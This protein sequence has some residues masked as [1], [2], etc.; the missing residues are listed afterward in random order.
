MASDGT[1]ETP[2]SR[3][4]KGPP[5][6]SNGSVWVG[7]CR[8]RPCRVEESRR[9]CASNQGRAD[10]FGGSST[11]RHSPQPHSKY[12]AIRIGAL[13][14]IGAIRTSIMPALHVGQDGRETGGD[15][16]SLTTQPYGVGEAFSGTVL[17]PAEI[18][19]GPSMRLHG[20]SA[21]CCRR[22]NN[23]YARK[24]SLNGYRPTKI[25]LGSVSAPGR[26]DQ[27]GGPRSSLT[28]SRTLAVREAMVYGFCSQP[29]GAA[30]AARRCAS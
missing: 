8:T 19:G 23:L 10:A 6:D 30:G 9:G 27:S 5:Q 14:S 25:G 7:G 28:A 18:R 2:N 12:R 16:L 26:L 1:I 29:S 17:F 3:R 22:T 15:C 13:H 24:M 21:F 20:S 4:E 11:V